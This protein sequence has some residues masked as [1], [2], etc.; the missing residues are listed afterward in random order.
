MW[1]AK[2]QS[3]FF[4]HQ[5]PL[6]SAWHL[7]NS[8]EPMRLR[9]PDSSN[10]SHVVLGNMCTWSS[11]SNPRHPQCSLG[12][13]PLCLFSRCGHHWQAETATGSFTQHKVFFLRLWFRKTVSLSLYDWAL[14]HEGHLPQTPKKRSIYLTIRCWDIVTLD[15]YV[16]PHFCLQ[17]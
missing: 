10:V 4:R 13:T 16:L 12:E 5:R 6:W 9:H 3:E 15:C 14:L 8:L 7:L 1:L 11:S 17:S 2:P